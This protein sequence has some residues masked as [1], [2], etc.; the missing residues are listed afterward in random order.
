MKKALQVGNHKSD[1]T[2]DSLDIKYIDVF[3][4]FLDLL[5]GVSTVIL[6]KTTAKINNCEF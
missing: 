4:L 3:Q 5:I 6:V 2:S 1:D